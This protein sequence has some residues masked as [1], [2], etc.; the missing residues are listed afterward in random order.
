MADVENEP[1]LR[2]VSPLPAGDWDASL[3]RV[4]DDMNDAPL[5]IHALMA[6]H[7][8]LLNAWWSFRN[9]AVNGGA[10]SARD[11]ELVILRVAVRL[12]NKYEWKSHVQ[13]ARAGGLSIEEINRVV[14]GPQDPLWSARDRALLRAVDDCIDK[15]HVTDDT[16][17]ALEAFFSDQQIMDII[18]IQG[19]YLILGAMIETWRVPL[20]AGV[21]TPQDAYDDF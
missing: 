18:S 1:E 14:R 9:H 11:G 13:R 21:V 7:P 20:D 2:V 17:R 19:M 4:I 8:A 12:R 6:N 15:R 10:L 5:N 16:R 3:R